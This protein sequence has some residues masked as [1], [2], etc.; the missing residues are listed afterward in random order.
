METKVNL[1]QCATESKCF[2]SAW[3]K[4][5]KNETAVNSMFLDSRINFRNAS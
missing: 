4:K 5:T 2:G 3:A 1:K